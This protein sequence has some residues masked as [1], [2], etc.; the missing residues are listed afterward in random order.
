MNQTS[1]KPIHVLLN[2]GFV[3]ALAFTMLTSCAPQPIVAHGKY[4]ISDLKSGLYVE[5]TSFVYGLP[6][7]AGKKYRLVQAYHSKHLSHQNEFSL[8]FKMK[9]GSEVC[10]ARAGIVYDVKDDS[11][12]G[13]IGDEFL[14][15]GNYIVIKHDDST[16][17]GYWHLMLDGVTVGLGESVKQGQ[18]IGYS[19]NT[20]YSAFPHL[21]FFIFSLDKSFDKQS[22]PCRFKTKRGTVYLRPGQRYQRA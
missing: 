7:E 15:K 12:I 10:A 21:H 3:L 1:I 19:G 16:F 6:Y 13:G 14:T 8:D 11:D 5:D 4:T 2:F 17:A 9:E 18:T 20:G 22:I